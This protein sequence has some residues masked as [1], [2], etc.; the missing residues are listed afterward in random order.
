MANNYYKFHKFYQL[1]QAE[2]DENHMLTM[3]YILE[4][5]QQITG[6]R[7][8]RRTVYEYIEVLN[9]LGYDI[10]NFNENGKGYYIR[11]RTF[12]EHE[13]RILMDC[14]SAC[15]SVTHKKTKELIRKL[16]GLNSRYITGNL[17]DQLYIDNRSKSMNQ[18]I[19]YSIDSINRAI[20]NN[21]KISFNY[22][23]YDINKKLIPKMK[24]GNI[25]LYVVNPVAMIL[26]KDSYYLVGFSDNHKEPSHYR[27]DRM[28]KVGIKEENRTPLN[29]VE[30]FKEGFDPAVY[31]K[32]CINMYSGRDM[33]V[34]IRCDKS[35]LDAVIDELGE[36]VELKIEDEKHFIASFT[37]KDSNGFIRWIMQYGSDIQVIEPVTLV[38]KIKREIE[39]MN[40]L[41]R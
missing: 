30:E 27:V 17:K 11:S 3:K 16:E 20:L 5:L 23:H 15:R 8:D 28:Q 31:S 19:F 13:V 26:K 7:I 40:L 32:K 36:D 2:S 12:E 34:L 29:E 9:S 33:P 25:K 37:S 1:L 39:N 6:D 4:K 18:H 24:N 41:Y 21:K 38:E 35:L 22:C 10:S 14:V